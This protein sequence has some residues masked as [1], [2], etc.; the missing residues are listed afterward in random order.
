MA[1]RR[2]DAQCVNLALPSSLDTSKNSIIKVFQVIGLRTGTWLYTL[3]QQS[4]RT[5]QHIALVPSMTRKRELSKAIDT[6]L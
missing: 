1:L 3:T 5:K 4:L 6:S 2:P